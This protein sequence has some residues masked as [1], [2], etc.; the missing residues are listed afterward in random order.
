MSQGS[1]RGATE[2]N[3]DAIKHREVCLLDIASGQGTKCQSILK[4][5]KNVNSSNRPEFSGSRLPA[6]QR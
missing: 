3:S 6:R 5:D 2:G 1:V 4:R